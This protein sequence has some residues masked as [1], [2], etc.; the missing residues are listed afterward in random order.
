M[1]KLL[2]LLISIFI[3]SSCGSKKSIYS[4]S[5]EDLYKQ[6]TEELFEKEGGFPWIFT[7]ASYEKIFEILK[8]IQLRHTFSPFATLAE[9]RT[10]DA[11]FKKGE[12]NQAIIEYDEFIKN[13]P[14]H[15]EISYAIYQLALSHY[16]NMGGKD[17]DPTSAR[18]SIK[19]FNVFLDRYPDSELTP[20][21]QKK[22]KKSRKV[23]AE[24]EIYIGKYYLKKKNYNA[25][26][27]RFNNVLENYSD[28]KYKDEAEKLLLKIPSETDV[29]S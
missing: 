23:L 29:K 8:E 9:I 18:E 21:A 16:K 25:A 17:R 22:I 3:L 15:Q 14:G 11:Y 4:D 19:W 6:A 1:K 24:R 26:K 10:A 12:Y 2:I 27:A 7:G 28:T 13:H 20:K 5:A